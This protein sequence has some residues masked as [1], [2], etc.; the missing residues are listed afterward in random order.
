MFETI[1][2]FIVILTN[3]NNIYLLCMSYYHERYIFLE[4]STV[5]C[6]LSFNLIITRPIVRFLSSS[7][8]SLPHYSACFDPLRWLRIDRN[9]CEIWLAGDSVFRMTSTLVPPM[10]I[11]HFDRLICIMYKHAFGTTEYLQIYTVKIVNRILN[12]Q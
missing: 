1:F 12:M 5:S 10:S 2:I 11:C 9:Y 4:L 7:E 8:L 6:N 3:E